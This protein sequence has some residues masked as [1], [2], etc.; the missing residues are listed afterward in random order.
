[1]Q[2]IVT[3]D[4]ALRTGN[5]DPRNGTKNLET[6]LFSNFVLFGVFVRVGS[7]IDFLGVTLFTTQYT[8]L[9]LQNSSG[10][11]YH[12]ARERAVKADHNWRD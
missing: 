6:T 8:T 12:A 10:G 9:P 4:L 7:W 2:Q 5:D 11:R 1:M 3:Y